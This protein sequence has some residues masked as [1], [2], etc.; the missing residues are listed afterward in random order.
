MKKLML[1]SFLTLTL[2]VYAGSVSQPAEILTA[3]KSPSEYTYTKEYSSLKDAP[4]STLLPKRT[5][6]YPT[7][8]VRMEANLSGQPKSCDQVFQHIDAFFTSHITYDKFLYNTI[9]YCTFD[10]NTHFATKFMI[11]SYF[12]PVDENA[13]AYL[14]K[15]IT[16]HNGRNL[17]GS[18]FYVENAKGLVV[19]LNI[20][21]GIE[22]EKDPNTLLRLEHDNSGHYFSSNYTMMVDLKTDIYQRFYSNNPDV[23]LPFIDKWFLTSM[24]LYQRALSKANY[25]ELQP[26]LVFLMEKGPEIFTPK[27]RMYYA[28]HCSKYE[29]QH[30]L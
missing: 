23:I 11:D 15:Y 17:L 27:L 25:V 24:L 18:P 22:D 5:A 28:H 20:D 14:Q 13:A 3:A 9:L 6:D 21:V 4:A 7:Q 10:P 29:N 16:N 30:C 8:I 12:D 2:P 19:S 26:E 1:Y